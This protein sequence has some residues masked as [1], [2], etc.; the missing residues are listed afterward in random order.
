MF[1]SGVTIENFR[2]FPAKVEV[3][4]SPGMN[5][6]LGENNAGKSAIL[7]AFSLNEIPY[8]PHLSMET[9]PFEDVAISGVVRVGF[10]FVV[11]KDE[12]FRFLGKTV[13]FPIPESFTVVQDFTSYLKSLSEFRFAVT[14]SV[15]DNRKWS[16]FSFFMDGEEFSTPT[17]LSSTVIAYSCEEATGLYAGNITR[18]GIR[19]I[20]GGEWA[21]QI[22]NAIQRV[23][24]FRAERMNITRA[25]HGVNTSLAANSANLAECLNLLQSRNP[26]LFDEYVQHV[27][28]VFPS[29]HRIQVV[30]FTSAELEIRALLTPVENR[31]PDLSIPL[32]QAGTGIGQ[33][34]S[35]LYVA[36]FHS[37]P[38]TIAI[39]EPNSFLHPKAVRTLMQILNTLPTKHQYIITT[40]SPEVIRAAAPKSVMVVR[41]EDGVSKIDA[42]DPDNFEHIK[43]G[44]ASIGARLSDLYGADRIL[45]VEGETE[46]LTFP[47]IARKVG[48]FDVIGVTMLKVNATG[49]FESPKRIRPKMV[50]DTYCQLSTAG[51]LLPPA[52]GFVFDSEGRAKSDMD[53]LTKE[54]GNK[55]QFLPRLCFENYILHA[56]AIAAALT[57]ACGAAID[58]ASVAS[59]IQKHGNDKAYLTPRVELED[60]EDLLTNADWLTRVHAPKLLKALFSD[61]TNELLGHPEEYR[62]TTHSVAISDWLVNTEPQFLQPL[63]DVLQTFFQRH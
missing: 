6:I 12:L 27:R 50:F 58:P 51:A 40:H 18:R 29:V 37:A 56:G 46:E 22:R 24:K 62:K 13:L 25:G 8:N 20:E 2:S 14:C 9:K 33:V 43:A 42:L 17:E 32:S 36:M 55:V 10:R 54:S 53:L 4:F 44:L 26:H 28:H 1:I 23:Y 61:L 39:D 60:G 47:D 41:N 15:A 7:E 5:L 45:W 30:P 38:I 63:A 59:W 52:I 16:S 3:T 19:D 49:D 34:L 57:E 21:P 31:R 35:I 11:K 48:G